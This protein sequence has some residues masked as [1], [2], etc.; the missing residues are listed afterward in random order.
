LILYDIEI[1]NS[2]PPNVS[3][4]ALEVFELTTP[5][6]VKGNMFFDGL[7]ESI[8]GSEKTLKEL[9]VQYKAKNFNPS[10]FQNLELLRC[11]SL[12]KVKFYFKINLQ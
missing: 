7:L 10:I 2:K 11:R 4:T 3:F 12:G 6:R 8:G 9:I 1:S 5:K